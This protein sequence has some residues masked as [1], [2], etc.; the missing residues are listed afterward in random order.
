MTSTFEDKVTSLLKNFLSLRS[1]KREEAIVRENYEVIIYKSKSCKMAIYSSSN[2]GE[3]NCKLGKIEAD[4][5][6]INGNNWYYLNSLTG[7]NEELS[8]EELLNAI[9]S[10]PQGLDE[11]LL[12]TIDNINKN[13]DSAEQVLSKKLAIGEK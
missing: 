2:D 5:T 10:T 3:I 1:M 13:F 6:N 11:Q 8:I 7:D 9:P 12:E 4:N